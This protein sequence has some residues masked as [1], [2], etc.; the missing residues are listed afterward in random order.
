MWRAAARYRRAF[1]RD[2][3]V[4][5]GGNS[6]SSSASAHETPSTC[7]Q[8][9]QR[10]LYTAPSS[11]GSTDG[12]LLRTAQS[13]QVHVQVMTGLVRS[14]GDFVKQ[15][16]G[17]Q[18]WFRENEQV[19]SLVRRYP[20]GQRPGPKFT[21][22]RSAAFAQQAAAVAVPEVSALEGAQQASVRSSRVSDAVIAES[23]KQRQDMEEALYEKQL[24]LE[25]RAVDEAV[26]RYKKLLQEAG[27]RGEVTS[28]RPSKMLAARWFRRLQAAIAEEQVKILQQ[29]K[30]VDRGLY[31]P[32]LMMLDPAKLAVITLHTTLGIM[33]SGVQENGSA[34][35]VQVAINVGKAVQARAN[36]DALQEKLD[37]SGENSERRKRI[38]SIMKALSPKGPGNPGEVRLVNK[39]LRLAMMDTDWPN[40]VAAKVGSALV[41]LLLQTA[42]VKS[43]SRVGA[44][45]MWEH[46]CIPGSFFIDPVKYKQLHLKTARKI[47]TDEL[48]VQD[49]SESVDAPGGYEPAF[50]HC[51]ILEKKASRRYGYLVCHK[52]VLAMVKDSELLQEVCTPRY[53]PMVVPPRDWTSYNTGA[54][55]RLRATVMRTRGHRV[56]LEALKQVPPQQLRPVYKALNVVGKV[57]WRINK[58]V[59]DVMMRVWREGGGVAEIPQRK[60]FDIPPPPAVAKDSEAYTEWKRRA[61]RIRRNNRELHSLV[62]DTQYKLQVARDLCAY[63]KFYYPHNL[64]FRGRAYPLHPFLNH[65]GSDMC[66]GTLEFGEGRP[67]GKAGF[68]WLEIHLANVYG[69]GANKLPLKQRETFASE[70]WDEILDSAHFP[71]DGRQ[72]WKGADDPWQ[73]LATCIELTDA[74]QHA[75]THGTMESFIS[76]LPVHQDGSC[77]GLQ[78]YAALGRDEVGGAEVNLV[79]ADKPGDVYSSIAR[80]VAERVKQKAAQGHQYAQLCDG[81]VDRKLVKQT[82][83]TS[84][85]GVTFVGARNQIMAR[86]KEKNVIADHRELYLAA[87]YMAR[88]TLD[89]LGDLF[90]SA[91]TI[92]E[93]LSKC[94]R[95]IALN[96]RAVTWETPL[97]LPVVQPYRRP[98]HRTVRTLLQLVTVAVDDMKEPVSVQRQKMAFPPNYVHSLD[99]SHMMLTA[100][101]CAEK[102]LCFAGVH[103]SFWTH[104]ADVDV[105]NQTLREEFVRLHKRPLLEELLQHFQRAHPDVQFPPIPPQGKLDVNAVLTSRYFFN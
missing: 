65:L 103:D 42:F 34:R 9:V 7:Q 25:T 49:L 18:G 53:L 66:R 22:L 15:T 91:K 8:R 88:E 57:P 26:D 23:K 13:G 43:R 97:G 70:H 37:S 31:G 76:H 1:L 94:A 19:A 12:G 3:R 69:N 84:V 83:M 48:E 11:S 29:E 51:Y 85:Y 46:Y 20:Q 67:L 45:G 44:D 4:R 89:G 104:A 50:K 93:W 32:Y 6:A 92:M 5:G 21:A 60:P 33:L 36:L 95:L 72:W 78:H 80:A 81:H 101:K 68:K 52:E 99:S 62:C 98:A 100:V 86:L 35:V 56:H 16:T 14:L 73:C 30:G 39:N 38:Q 17:V 40:E 79:V 59:L 58:P 105:M 55:L 41:K 102:G 2:L 77:N 10:S 90:T 61:A 24:R 27:Q 71:L 28:L 82:V 96:K 63:E 64:D 75:E 47:E 87:C 74:W 54:H